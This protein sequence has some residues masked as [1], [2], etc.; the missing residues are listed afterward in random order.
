MEPEF[1][2]LDP[3]VSFCLTVLN[4]TYSMLS[5]SLKT[6]FVSFKN[7]ESNRPIKK[8][9]INCRKG[10]TNTKQMIF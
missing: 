7:L 3:K 2:L 5:F 1:N 6:K 9:T 8:T 10:G 4:V